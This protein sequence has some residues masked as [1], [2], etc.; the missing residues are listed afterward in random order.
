MIAIASTG[1][2]AAQPDNG[3]SLGWAWVGLC[4]ALAVNVTDEALTDFL[5]V[6]NPTVVALRQR[7]PWLPLPTFTFGV[8]LAVLIA[9]IVLLLLLSPFAFRGARWIALLSYPV[10]VLML[11]NV[12]N[13]IAW[14]IYFGK[15][16]PG[17]YS[18][19]LL[20]IASAYLLLAAHRNRRHQSA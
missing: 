7:L 17:V 12:L 16:M 9:A 8:W 6:Y 18:S 14:S 2:V 3:R 19:P 5:S 4:A 13:H 20:L 11:L 1:N 10:G 15:W